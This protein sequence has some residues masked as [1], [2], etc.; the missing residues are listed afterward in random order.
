[1]CGTEES[2]GYDMKTHNMTSVKRSTSLNQQKHQ[3]ERELVTYPFSVEYRRGG[4]S[5]CLR[6]LLLVLTL[7]FYSAHLKMVMETISNEKRREG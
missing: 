6:P 2:E 5:D 1:M 7:S 4:G 3:R